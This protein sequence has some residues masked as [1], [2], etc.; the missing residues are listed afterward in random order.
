MMC[1]L[2]HSWLILTMAIAAT[3][4]VGCVPAESGVTQASTGT[5]GFNGTGGFTGLGEPPFTGVGGS[6]PFSCDA[7]GS[8]PGASAGGATSSF[9]GGNVVFGGTFQPQLGATVT[10]AVA[11][12]AISGGT[13]RVLRDGHT[14]IA[15]DPD[16]DRITVVDLK[17]AKIVATISLQTGDEPGRV[18]ED[19]AGRV[20]VALR[21]GGALATLD[22]A[23]WAS[24]NR[25]SVCAAPRGLAYEAKTDLVHV[26]CADGQLV[27]LPAAGGVATRTIK[28]DRDLRDVVVDGDRLL[29]SRFR[30]AQVLTLDAAGTVTQRL[31]PAP[32]RSGDAHQ[33]SLFS[34]SVAWRM[35]EMPGGGAA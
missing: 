26:A 20:H 25:R 5:G 4:V 11:P 3:A 19:A 22:P 15:A 24:V 2:L 21:R 10:P 18:V 27:A 23:S 32:F 9:P 30:S 31:T 33:N 14:A 1:K 35:V 34:A 12:P 28:L 8:S 7:P 6:Q 17:T 29:V 13:L 16:R